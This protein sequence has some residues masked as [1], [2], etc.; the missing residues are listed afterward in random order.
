[1][2]AKDDIGRARGFL[3]SQPDYESA[4]AVIFG[5]PMDWTT[6]FRPG[7]R[8][9]PTRIREASWGLEDYSFA[10]DRS[11]QEI[12]FYD[13]GDLELPFGNVAAGL[14][15]AAEAT[16]RF[17]NDGK[18]PFML[19]GEHLVSLPV[20]KEVKA[21]YDDLR[22]LHFDA[23]ADLRHQFFG[24]EL[25]HATVMRRVVEVIGKGNLYQIGIRSG[26]KEEYEFAAENTHL[27]RGDFLTAVDQ[28]IASIGDRPLYISL[29][30]DAV[31]PA[32]APGTG[33]PEPGGCTS[34][35]IIEAVHRLGKARVVGFDL[36]EVSPAYDPSER[37]TVLAA[38]I[39]REAILSYC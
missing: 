26:P 20:I 21:K 23:H 32:F 13:W 34:A 17:L 6:S 30:I 12:P 35:E 28:A 3:M 22:V 1:M 7:T 14:R 19:G 8:L 9:G 18:M 11:L 31:D 37:T 25:S 2:A 33:T 38:K 5:I 24:E 39:L 36:V 10:V 15:I 29:D 4:K 16:R 27:L